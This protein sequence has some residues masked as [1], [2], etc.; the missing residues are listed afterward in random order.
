MLRNWSAILTL[1]AASW[2][3]PAAELTQLD[4]LAAAAATILEKAQS[5]DRTAVI[6][7]Q[8]KTAFDGLTEKMRYLKSHFLLAPPLTDSDLVSLGLKPRDTTHTPIP[9][10]TEQAEADILRPGVHLLE[11]AL[12]V[13]GG[14]ALRS[15]VGF[16]VYW[17]VL[18]HGGADITAAASSKRELMKPPLSGE[19]LPFSRF[20]K[21]RRER[22]D[23]DAADSGKTAYFCIRLENA[24]GE[25]GPW[26]TLFSAVIP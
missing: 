17:G 22:F 21:R 7:A 20:T 26:G 3:L 5:A 6:T 11:L 18:P 19:E 4:A 14:G 25:P 23:F 2:N 12:R 1:K 8:C 9:P 13:I 15:G 24:K 16:R 10:P